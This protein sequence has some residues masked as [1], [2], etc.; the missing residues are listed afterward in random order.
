MVSV[1]S[2]F[3][4]VVGASLDLLGGAS[5]ARRMWERDGS[6][7]SDD[8]ALREDL[9]HWLGW[10]WVP[11]LMQ[12]EAD[13]LRGFVED[14]RAEGF[15]HAVVLGMGGSS[16]A[17]E[18]LRETFGVAPGYLALDVLD[19]TD[20]DAILALERRLDLPRT[21]FIVASKSGTTTE[22][23]SFMEYFWS[24]APHGRQFAAITDPGTPLEATARE[25]GFRR[26]FPHPVEVGGRYAALTYIGMLPAACIGVDLHRLLGRAQTMANA[27]APEVPARDNPGL[28]LGAAIGGLARR[29]RDKLT[30]ICSPG[31]GT[32]GYWAEQLVAESTGKAG[33]GILPVEGEPLGPPSVYGPDRQFVY[34][35]LEDEPD[36]AQDA[37]VAALEGAGFPV[38]RIPLR[39]RYDLGG[40]FFHWEFAVPVAAALIG[41]EP[42]EQPN[43]QESKDNT[44]RLLKEYAEKGTL[45]QPAPVLTG[46]GLGLYGQGPAA[47]A[48]DGARTVVSA[49]KGFLALVQPLDYVA[50]TAY[51]PP[52]GA[53]ERLLD[54]MRTEVRDR[55]HVAT[56]AGYGPRFLHS[57]GQL[58][59]GGGPGGVFVQI[60]SD[61]TEDVQV[62]GRPYT[63]GVLMAAQALG[64]MQSLQARNRRAIRVH[65]GT[66]VDG[67]LERLNAALRQALT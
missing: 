35:R 20:P 1:T 7:W 5:F 27:C 16:L 22:A 43:V 60:T 10:L 25:R 11:E 52:T 31:V 44:N 33:T 15:D 40:E 39:D 21:L 6:L 66:D 19:T 32:F 45:P 23:V 37:A 61:P 49:L 13:D 28:S 34:L 46:D 29:G 42:F 36:G 58:H 26:I 30:L 57:T 65:L 8:P 4:T 51:V 62:P 24:K 38:I 59:K 9:S 63:F 17:P 3:A 50:F 48:I 64:D 18:V 12:A 41:V 67:G 55:L 56:T 54:A 53:T 2:D 14:L 47:M